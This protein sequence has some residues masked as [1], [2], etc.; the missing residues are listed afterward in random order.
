MPSNVAVQGEANSPRPR[1]TTLAPPL[2]RRSSDAYRYGDLAMGHFSPLELI[3]AGAHRIITETWQ[4][5]HKEYDH[6]EWAYL[7]GTGHVD[8]EL[9][10]VWREEVWGRAEVLDDGVLE[11]A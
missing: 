7:F 4:R 2:P 6:E 1:L 9:A 8:E 11:E 10:Y 3:L 5:Q